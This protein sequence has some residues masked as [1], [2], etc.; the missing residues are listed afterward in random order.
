MTA[1]WL[2]RWLI[3]FVLLLLVGAT[4]WLLSRL[5]E[6]DKTADRDDRH[7]SD[8]FMEHL[9]RTT[10]D[11]EG[12]LKQRLQAD[13]ME[14]FPHDDRTELVRPYLELYNTQGEPW[15]VRAD[16]GQVSAHGKEILLKGQV[17]VWRNDA[18]GRREVEVLTNELRVLPEEEYA[19]T[20]V[21]AT[22]ISPSSESRGIGMRFFMKEKRLA[23]LSK[24]KT[25]YEGKNPFDDKDKPSD[26]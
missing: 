25:H 3:P 5:D 17:H 22:L 18:G 9:I 2:E 8:S 7:E 4:S 16:H 21:A 19:E 11:A 15:Q 12:K 1:S 6:N 10:M 24:V 23:L 20:R 14:H 26:P 13:Y